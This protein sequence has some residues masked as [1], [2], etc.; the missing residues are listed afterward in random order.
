MSLPIA[1]VTTRHRCPH[2]RKS[3]AHKA[4]AAQHMERCFSDPERRTCKTCKHDEPASGGWDPETGLD[5]Y[6]PRHCAEGYDQGPSCIECGA[7]PE[8]CGHERYKP[9]TLLT[10]LCPS[11]EAKP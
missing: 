8:V 9:A 2:C 11:W 5:D 7:H 6:E 3:Y 4:N 10:I 1:Y